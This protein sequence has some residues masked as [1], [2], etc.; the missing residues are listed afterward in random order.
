MIMTISIYPT[1]TETLPQFSSEERLWFVG[2][3]LRGKVTDLHETQYHC[4]T[5]K[6]L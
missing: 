5:G 3:I 6:E 2:E 4:N 1:T